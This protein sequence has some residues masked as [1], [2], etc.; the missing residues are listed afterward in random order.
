MLGELVHTEIGQTDARQRIEAAKGFLEH[1]R[2][3]GLIRTD[4]SLETELY[5]LAAIATG[6]VVVDQFLPENY[7]FPA[8]AVAAMIAETVRCIFEVRE[9]TPEEQQD[10]RKTFRHVADT[11]REQA[12]KELE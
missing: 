2:G 12:Q 10:T 8:E 5:M 4:L 6:F 9:P 7:Q 11:V 1:L 3:S